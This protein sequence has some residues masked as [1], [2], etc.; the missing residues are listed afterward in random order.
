MQVS[1][2]VLGWAMAAPHR[3]SLH[4]LQSPVSLFTYLV[5]YTVDVLQSSVIDW[6]RKMIFLCSTAFKEKNEHEQ[7]IN[8]AVRKK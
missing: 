3:P 6:C 1:I 8:G 7:I 2:G 4:C 5:F